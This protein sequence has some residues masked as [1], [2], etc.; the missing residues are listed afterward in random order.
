MKQVIL[1]RQDLKLPKGKLASQVAHASAE[2]LLRS[3]KEK[4]SGGFWQ[5]QVYR[6]VMRLMRKKIKVK[7]INEVKL[8]IVLSEFTAGYPIIRQT[9]KDIGER[10]KG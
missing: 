10:I 7:M 4:I 3:D 6:K 9:G 1:V 8:K 5:K 2:A